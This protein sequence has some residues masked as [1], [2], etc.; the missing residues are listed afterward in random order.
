MAA[1]GGARDGT[2]YL[3]D[4]RRAQLVAG[5]TDPDNRSSVGGKGNNMSWPWAFLYG[6]CDKQEAY[7]LC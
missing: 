7:T 3:G 5:M 2:P 4:E 1:G 6:V